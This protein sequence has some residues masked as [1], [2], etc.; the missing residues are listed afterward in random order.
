LED[1]CNSG[2]FVIRSRFR[3]QHSVDRGLSSTSSSQSSLA[4]LASLPPPPPLRPPDCS[5]LLSPAAATG[6][7]ELPLFC[8]NSQAASA[9]GFCLQLPP[10]GRRSAAANIT[11]RQPSAVLR[12]VSFG[13]GERLTAASGREEE[14]YRGGGGLGSFTSVPLFGPFPVGWEPSLLRERPRTTTQRRPTE[15]STRIQPE[16]KQRQQ[17]VTSCRSLSISSAGTYI[18]SLSRCEERVS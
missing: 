3:R 1:I 13:Q 14:E 2:I 15:E 17:E 10:V 8:G 4:S 6:T 5:A 18:P 16:V 11:A 7:N 9:G 12:S